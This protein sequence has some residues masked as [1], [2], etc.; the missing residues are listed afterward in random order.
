MLNNNSSN[1]NINK[2]KILTINTNFVKNLIG[3]TVFVDKIS[4]VVKKYDRKI[5]NKL[6]KVTVDL[7]N[8]TKEHYKQKIEEIEKSIKNTKDIKKKL[9][10]EVKIN[11]LKKKLKLGFKGLYKPFKIVI[12]ESIMTPALQASLLFKSSFVML[13]SYF[14]FLIGD[15]VGNYHKKY[16][17]KLLNAD[18]KINLKD[19]VELEN[20]DEAI[21]F[22]INNEVDTLLRQSLEEKKKYLKDKL[23]LDINEEII[24][25]DFV[26]EAVNI[27]NIIVHNNSR[28]NKQ[29]LRNIKK[30]KDT[31]IS[32]KENEEIKITKDYFYKILY[33]LYITG[34]ILIQTCWRYW[35]KNSIEEADNILKGD[36]NYLIVNNQFE[37]AEK[38]G[39]FSKKCKLFNEKNR[40]DLEFLYCQSLKS[41]NK[42]DKLEEEIKN[43]IDVS[44]LRP[45]NIL[46]LSGLKNDA[47]LFYSN[48]KSAIVVDGVKKDY[49]MKNF[50]FKEICE[51]R[52][53]LKNINAEF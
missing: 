20:I 21:S 38:L 31:N 17:N 30:L 10:L 51:D 3:L 11:N 39:L 50:F 13:I 32:L 5:E 4:P 16:P 36:L 15:L 52:D 9:K 22:V 45:K 53:F 33:E 35:D 28:V 34:I 18:I 40:L 7:V 48:L 29:Y 44:S 37:F 25:W 23:N 43:N 8:I 47:K 19:L 14:D 49:I 42:K 41:Q 46:K 6:N 24:N 27:R 12:S 26:N 2:N 1:K